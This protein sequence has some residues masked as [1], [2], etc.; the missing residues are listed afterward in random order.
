MKLEDEDARQERELAKLLGEDPENRVRKLERDLARFSPTPISAIEPG[1]AGPSLSA[2]LVESTTRAKPKRNA[3]QRIA[4]DRKATALGA[5]RSGVPEAVVAR[6][7]GISRKRI[8]QMR[9][10]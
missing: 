5:I 10:E 4:D 3:R 1:D 9:N 6:A 2:R 8:W 7:L